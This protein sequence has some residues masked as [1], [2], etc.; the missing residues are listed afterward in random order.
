M[1]AHEQSEEE[2]AEQRQKTKKVH[3]K[4][5][6][7]AKTQRWSLAVAQK[8]S[9]GFARNHPRAPQ[10]RVAPRVTTACKGTQNVLSVTSERVTCQRRALPAQDGHD[11]RAGTGLS[12]STA[13]RFSSPSLLLVFRISVPAQRAAVKVRKRGQQ[14]H[15]LRHDERRTGPRTSSP[16]NESSRRGGEAHT[17]PRIFLRRRE[18]R[19]DEALHL[20]APRTLFPVDL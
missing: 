8:R 10:E 16:R 3:H 18:T 4:P 1:R 7:W 11:T 20:R 14:F 19:R 6:V 17:K 12:S 5:E 15:N 13:E 2:W 9:V